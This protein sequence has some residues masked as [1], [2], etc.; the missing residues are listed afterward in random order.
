MIKDSGNKLIARLAKFCEGQGQISVGIHYTEGSSSHGESTVADIA[1]RHEFGLGVPERSFIRAWYDETKVELEAVM[2]EQL[3]LAL[4]RR[5]SFEWAAERVALWS[6]ASMQKRIANRIN[7]P[8]HPMT[9]KNKGSD[10]PLIDTGVL[11]ASILA[12]FN[13]NPVQ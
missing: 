7:P 13:G 6:Q 2:K 9:I 12:Y 3:R 8:L 4:E 1:E 10:V 5:E 11:K